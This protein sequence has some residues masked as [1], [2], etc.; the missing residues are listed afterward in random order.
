VIAA[1]NGHALAGGLELA[2]AGDFRLAS[3]NATFGLAETK[4]ALI[5]GAGGTQ[6]LPRAGP[7][8]HALEM[9]MTGSPVLAARAERI[10]LVNRVIEL[11]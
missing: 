10:G 1:V 8:G 9:L 7:I 5:A 2:L 3:P 11:D 6:R 4:W